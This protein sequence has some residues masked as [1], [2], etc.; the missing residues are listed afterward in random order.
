MAD[1]D[2]MLD[3][4]VKQYKPSGQP[5]PAGGQAKQDEDWKMWQAS[6]TPSGDSAQPGLLDR[7]QSF[8]QQHPYISTA[9]RILPVLG[10]A[11]GALTDPTEE[12]GKGALKQVGRDAYDLATSPAVGP[13]GPAAGYLAN[14][15]GIDQK[16]QTATE[17]SNDLQRAGSYGTTGAEMALPLPKALEALPNI[18]RAGQNFNLVQNAMKG[19]PV[20][21][22]A[23]APSILRAQELAKNASTWRPPVMRNLL[24]RISPGALQPTFREATDLGTEVGKLSASE[25]Q[26]MKG[27]MGGAVKQTAKA[28]SGATQEAANQGGVG[29][30]YKQAVDEY[31][32][33][34]AL[35]AAK[36]ATIKTVKRIAIPAAIGVTGYGAYRGLTGDH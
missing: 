8:A 4:A 27:P 18:E 14:K 12:A 34:K 13:L 3:E 33:A 5:S 7:A 29:D 2:Q 20:N 36:D 11:A 24:N 23:A 1:I 17:P 21:I 16:V 10:P 19:L 31:R 30:I 28:L 15:V 25:A 35:E 26:R 9:A 22:D 32:R 6:P